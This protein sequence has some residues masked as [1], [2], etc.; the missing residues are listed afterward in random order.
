MFYAAFERPGQ[1]PEAYIY[2]ENSAGYQ[3]FIRDTWNPDTVIID[4]FPLHVTGSSYQ[5]RKE[6][7][8]DLAQRF[9]LADSEAS[10]GGF[11]YG[12]YLTIQEFFAAAARRYGLTEEFRENCII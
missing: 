8:R 1:R 6:R 12:E 11:S 2:Y 7:A 3:A 5:E 4:R 9:Q 10:G